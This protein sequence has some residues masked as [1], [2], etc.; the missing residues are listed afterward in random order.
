MF[1][2]CGRDEEDALAAPLRGA[3]FGGMVLW[4]DVVDGVVVPVFG[5]LKKK[6]YNCIGQIAER[7]CRLSCEASQTTSL[8]ENQV[9]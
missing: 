5:G 1:S 3:A 4:C 6:N 2:V 7:Q 8:M 9:L